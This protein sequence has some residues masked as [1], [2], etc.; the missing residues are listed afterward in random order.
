M[1]IRIVDIGSNSIKAS[2]YDVSGQS[3]RLADKDKLQFSL[4][5][6]V[7]SSGSIT[8]EAQEKVAAFLDGLPAAH[9]GEKVHFTFVLATSAVRSARNRD[10]FVRK[11]SQRSGL[12]PRVLTGEEESFL[13][14]M[15]I[16]GKAGIGA[17]D[18]LTTIDI[19]GGSAEI[20]WS[21]G[22]GYL[23][24]HSY[25]LG[26]IRLTKRF[27][28]GGKALTREAAS[29]I[30]DLA[31]SEF[32]AAGVPPSFPAG[33]RA[34]G[35]SGNIRAVA[36]MVAAVRGLP[37]IK[38]VPEITPGSL[39]DVI[40]AAL[41]RAPQAL[42][43]LFDLHPERSRIVMPAVVVLLAAM[44]HFGIPRLEVSEAGLR[45]GAIWWWSRNGH[46]NLPVADASPAPAPEARA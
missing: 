29:Q 39:E 34:I 6:E 4:G 42:Q 44:R 20:S 24:G 11:L 13:I 33:S 35:S 8:E 32:K 41:G 46:F 9:G 3:H 36:K 2:I 22:M 26:A 38:L 19:G 23:A 30:W 1:L 45:E 28:K 37:F 40:E 5:E 14:H 16:A 21:R 17:G 43:Q 15:G 7:F 25:D 18:E 12:A 10:A 27:L 31:V